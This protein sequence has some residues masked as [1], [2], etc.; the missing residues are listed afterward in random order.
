MRSPSESPVQAV[1]I[2]A[3][4]TPMCYLNRV[5]DG[6]GGKIAAKLEIMEPCSSVK[7]RIGYSM[8]TEAEK[9]GQ[10][11]AGKV[12]L[13][14]AS[15][16]KTYHNLFCDNYTWPVCFATACTLLQVPQFETPACL[17]SVACDHSCVIFV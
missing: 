16:N 4:N 10:I 14:T 7:D 13:H 1:D 11:T 15:R 2:L 8:I 6:A 12:S 3:G 17:M 5:T 9:A